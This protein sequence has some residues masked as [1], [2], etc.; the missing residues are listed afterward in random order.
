[1]SKYIVCTTAQWTNDITQGSYD[2][3]VGTNGTYADIAAWESARDGLDAADEDSILHIY[4]SQSTTAVLFLNGWTDKDSTHYIEI[5]NSDDGTKYD[6]VVDGVGDTLTFSGTPGTYLFQIYENSVKIHDLRILYTGTSVTTLFIAYYTS[7]E[8]EV[9]NNVVHMTNGAASTSILR[10]TG[11]NT[12]NAHDN[13]LIAEDLGDSGYSVY[14]DSGPLTFINNTLVSK[15]GRGIFVD[16]GVTNNIKNNLN[17]AESVWYLGDSEADATYE[18]VPCASGASYAPDGVNCVYSIDESGTRLFNDLTANE[19][20]L[21]LNSSGAAFA[22]I[23]TAGIGP[24][25]DADISTTDILGNARSGT[26]CCMGAFEY[27]ASGGTTV[28]IVAG[29]IAYAGQAL[30]VNAKT[31]VEI[32]AGAIS[33][34][35]QTFK[36]SQA[37]AI[38]AGAISY[39]GKAVKANRAVAIAAGA[40]AYAGQTLKS[41]LIIKIGAGAINYI[42]RSV[43]IAGDVLGRA[44]WLLSFVR[45]RK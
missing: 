26:N 39:I 27:V 21:T 34:A 12:L 14:A 42:G 38:A 22:S 43:S 9:Y 35:G 19:E 1:M 25:S 10:C 36:A 16:T 29:A 13:F 37:V 6:G 40:I 3:Y 17:F 31:V 44:K 11:A 4:G 41:N 32:V 23:S 18:G 7:G 45:R 20:D 30:N 28:Q 2:G 33:Y 5:C 8:T 24:T 15:N